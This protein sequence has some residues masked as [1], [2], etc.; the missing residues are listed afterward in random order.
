MAFCDFCTCDD[1]QRGAVYL[2]HAPTDD[3]RHICDVCWHYDCCTRAL[4]RG[5]GPC[6][7]ASGIPIADCGHRPKLAGPW[8][9]YEP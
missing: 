6:E 9:R 1:C 2:S 5:H 7:D 3:G 4:G 8:S